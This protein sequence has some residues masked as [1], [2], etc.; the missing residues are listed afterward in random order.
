MPPSE[1][2]MSDPC[3]HQCGPP[4]PEPASWGG[5]AEWARAETS[6]RLH[7]GVPDSTYHVGD[8]GHDQASLNLIGRLPER[9]E[10]RLEG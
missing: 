5:I 4:L 10:H 9:L 1:Y 6:G 7:V 8:R 3:P 2:G